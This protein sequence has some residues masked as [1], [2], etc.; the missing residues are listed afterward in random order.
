MLSG[1]QRSC[2]TNTLYCKY[3]P[4]EFSSPNIYLIPCDTKTP[5]VISLR[6]QKKAKVIRIMKTILKDIIARYYSRTL[7]DSAKRTK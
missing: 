3:E 1:R 4:H 6:L 5:F 2:A 7:L